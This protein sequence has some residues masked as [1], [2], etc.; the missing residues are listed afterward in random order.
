M[1]R[2]GR[3]VRGVAL[4][5]VA[6]A[7]AL[8]CGVLLATPGGEAKVGAIGAEQVEASVGFVDA[9]ELEAYVAEIGARLAAEVDGRDGV[10]FEFHVVEMEAPNAFALPGGYVYVSRGL[11]ALLND[12]DELANVLGH[13]VAH[14]TS[15]H[16][17]KHALRQTPFIP[18]RIA[19]GL[20]G[21]V[22]SLATAPLGR[23]GAPIRLGAATVTGLGSAPGA[24]YLA[25]HSR[26]Q[27]NEAD[28]VGQT[29]AAKAGWDPAGMA[30]AM[31]ALSRDAQLHGR[32]PNALHFLDTH[33]PTP[34]RDRSTL[35]R[36]KTLPRAERAPI[37]PDRAHF[38]AK[39]AGLLVGPPASA[40]VIHGHAFYHADLDFH[41]AFPKGWVVENGVSNVTASPEVADDAEPSGVFATLTIASEGDDPAEIA[42]QVL[43]RSSIR[44]DGDVKTGKI[45][46][47]ASASVE[48]RDRSGGVPYH[49][50]VHWIAHGG[51]VY[52]VLGAAP[53]SEWDTQRAAL[54]SV[55]ETF[56]PL[57][58]KDQK[59][60]VEKRLRIASAREGESLPAIV[61]RRAAA[62]NVATA[63]A[64]N[65][66]PE[67]VTFRLRQPV[68]L[69]LWERY[70]PPPPPSEE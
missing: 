14:V 30:R 31:E 68:K 70:T 28:E 65:G 43:D 4:C 47:L 39:L 21:A 51:Q 46:S 37:V 2:S 19:A 58:A 42:R 10:A 40:G 36:A 64:A 7:F 17:L 5:A 20:A 12:E 16:H 33:P 26:G 41:L 67:D 38:Y 59:H 57:T 22:V 27:E 34:E 15:R 60:I 63:A 66:L 32:D 9:P 25:S 69:A 8:G 23:L 11:L 55:A 24:L 45:G 54:A 1:I 52:Q 29:I 49:L 53:A 3:G 44:T 35:E 61:E 50:I 6:G 48:G 62:W 56:R 18:V 13:E